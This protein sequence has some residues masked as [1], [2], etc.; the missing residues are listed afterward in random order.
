MTWLRIQSAVGAVGYGSAHATYGTNLSSGTKLIAVSVTE[1]SGITTSTVKDG[2]GNSFTK[3]FAQAQGGTRGELSLWALDTPSG[4]VGTKPVIT[5]TASAGSNCYIMVQEV[6]GLLTGN[7][8]AMAD[9][10]A[11]GAAGVTTTGGGTLGSPSYSSTASGEY[12]LSACTTGTETFTAPASL[13]A[14]ANN[15]QA[16]GGYASLGFAYGNSTSGTATYRLDSLSSRL[17]PVCAHPGGVD[18]GLN[19]SCDR[20]SR[21]ASRFHI[22]ARPGSLSERPGRPSRSGGFCC[23]PGTSCP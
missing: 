7:T 19:R 10:T 11:G 3:I 12:L 5:M 16:T 2:A 17:R 23:I 20:Y 13:T 18:F 1:T 15:L 21:H 8:T 6:S 4:D 22:A 9:G 14:D